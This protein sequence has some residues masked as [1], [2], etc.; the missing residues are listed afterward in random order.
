MRFISSRRL[1]CSI[2]VRASPGLRT[3]AVSLAVMM[4]CLVHSL[5]AVRMGMRV[6]RHWS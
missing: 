4:R 2:F 3:M 5:F 6:V 1:R